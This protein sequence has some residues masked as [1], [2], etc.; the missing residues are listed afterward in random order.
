MNSLSLSSHLNILH[1]TYS[2]PML[3]KIKKDF[4][5]LFT[6]TTTITSLC[7]S[8]ALEQLEPRRATMT[9]SWSDFVLL[10]HKDMPMFHP[11]PSDQKKI[12]GLQ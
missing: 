9:I 6:K 10:D 4:T 8:L 1:T 7:Q 5:L 2:R 12:T 11:Q 3:Q